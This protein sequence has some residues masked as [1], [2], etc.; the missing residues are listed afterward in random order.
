MWFVY[1]LLCQDGSL[2][3]GI[4]TDVAERLLA[5]QQGTGAKYTRAHP[6]LKVLHTEEYSTRSLASKRESEIKKWP[7]AKKI[8]ELQLPL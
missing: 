2:Y 4:T 1:V 5:H 8:S 3:T 7:R 6:P